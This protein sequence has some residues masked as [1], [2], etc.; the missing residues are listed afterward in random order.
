MTSIS[1]L[2]SVIGLFLFIGATV[3]TVF[4]F[5]SFVFMFIA[6]FIGTMVFLTMLTYALDAMG[7]VDIKRDDKKIRIGKESNISQDDRI[8]MIKQKFV[9]GDI[10]EQELEE[11]L[12]SEFSTESTK[13]KSKQYE[14]II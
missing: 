5:V 9:N 8:E 14:R 6:A 2:I 1:R 13:N 10:S 11:M 4:T 12:D 3:L 7:A